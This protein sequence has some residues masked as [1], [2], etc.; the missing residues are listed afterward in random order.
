MMSLFY[1]QNQDQTYHLIYRSMVSFV[2]S[3]ALYNV[4]FLYANRHRFPKFSVL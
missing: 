2:D 3:I 1:L 4:N